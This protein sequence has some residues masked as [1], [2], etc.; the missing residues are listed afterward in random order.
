MYI[1]LAFLSLLFDM[2]WHL[3]GTYSHFSFDMLLRGSIYYK[4]PTYNSGIEQLSHPTVK[5]SF[6]LVPTIEII[7]TDFHKLVLLIVQPRS[8]LYSSPCSYLSS[9]RIYCQSSVWLLKH[10][11]VSCGTT[12]SLPTES[13]THPTERLVG[14]RCSPET[15]WAL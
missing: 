10:V 12:S 14:V 5:S 6:A 8:R 4:N 1:P 11:V 2:S 13:P 15:V 9:A 7:F 3:F